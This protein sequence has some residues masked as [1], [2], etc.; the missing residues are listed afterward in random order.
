MK[1]DQR[2][3]KSDHLQYEKEK[4]SDKDNRRSLNLLVY[5]LKQMH[6]NKILKKR[7]KRENTKNK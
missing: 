2:D 4:N 3:R 5:K 1:D 7:K 6:T